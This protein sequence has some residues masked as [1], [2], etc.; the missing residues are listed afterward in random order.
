[1]KTE[2]IYT[3]ELLSNANRTMAFLA[4]LREDRRL[5][6]IMVTNAFIVGME[7]RDRMIAQE[8]KKGGEGGT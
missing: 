3:K 8:M 4:D 7:A 6:A 1:M 5:M 2:K